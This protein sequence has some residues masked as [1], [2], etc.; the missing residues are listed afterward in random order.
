MAFCQVVA[1]IPIPVELLLVTP[2]RRK[3]MLSNEV[4]LGCPD[5]DLHRDAVIPNHHSVEGTIA[6]GFGVLDVVLEAACHWLPQVVHLHNNSNSN[7]HS[8]H[9]N[10]NSSNNDKFSTHDELGTCNVG[11]TLA[12]DSKVAIV[13]MKCCLNICALNEY[14]MNKDT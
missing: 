12:N 4:H 9:C 5:L 14:A 7:S 1:L 2:V 10:N 3:A 8:N 13:Y 6:I 11:G